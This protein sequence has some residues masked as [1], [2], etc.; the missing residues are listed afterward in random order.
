M[1]PPYITSKKRPRKIISK[2]HENKIIPIIA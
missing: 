1:C 2:Y